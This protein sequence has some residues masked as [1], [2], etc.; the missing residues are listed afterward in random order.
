MTSVKLL[1]TTLG[2]SY[3]RMMMADLNMKGM[4]KLLLEVINQTPQIALLYFRR[5]LNEVYSVDVK[6]H[7]INTIYGKEEKLLCSVIIFYLQH[8]GICVIWH[9]QVVS[10]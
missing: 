7:C 6:Y 8:N 2:F 4:I 10:R 5:F 3:I 9:C 1:E